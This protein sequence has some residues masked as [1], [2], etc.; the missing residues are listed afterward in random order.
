MIGILIHVQEVT[1]LG[2]PLEV[3]KVSTNL[4]GPTISGTD[5]RIRPKWRRTDPKR[6]LRLS[7]LLFRVVVL[8]VSTKA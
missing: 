4:T 5:A 6:W 1:T 8:P 3:L 2:Q 7:R